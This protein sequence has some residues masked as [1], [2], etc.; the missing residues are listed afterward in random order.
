MSFSTLLEHQQALFRDFYHLDAVEDY[1]AKHG[2]EEGVN[3]GLEEATEWVEEKVATSNQ[4]VQATAGAGM[5]VS[6]LVS[7][8]PVGLY[9]WG[10]QVVEEAPNG[11]GAALY[12][13]VEVPLVGLGHGAQYVQQQAGRGLEIGK[14]ICRGDRN[15]T[16]WE[17]ALGVTT[18]LGVAGMTAMGAKGLAK[19][20]DTIGKNP[21]SVRLEPAMAYATSGGG[22]AIPSLAVDLGGL[23]EALSDVGPVLVMMSSA[24][25]TI[26]DKGGRSVQKP[27][28]PLKQAMDELDRLSVS[29]RSLYELDHF[30]EI[31]MTDRFQLPNDV[32]HAIKRMLSDVPA[33]RTY[34]E[35]AINRLVDPP[36]RPAVRTRLQNDLKPVDHSKEI[37][38]S[39]VRGDPRDAWGEPSFVD[40]EFA[41]FQNEG[42]IPIG[43]SGTH[44]HGGKRAWGFTEEL[45]E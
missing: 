44:G 30:L 5:G 24:A 40:D 33:F 32:R 10:K 11:A 7:G 22:V 25:G 13:F 36:Q 19:G 17:V 39:L 14:E 20:I 29:V 15:V 43:Y 27:S 12:K 26:G 35:N 2:L 3:I 1:W 16:P 28:P 21:P 37:R 45:I 23:G 34:Y 18:T 8:I 4:F 42:E 41:R 38:A 31:Y 6:K 9:S